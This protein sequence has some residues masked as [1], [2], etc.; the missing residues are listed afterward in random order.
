MTSKFY[1]MALPIVS[2]GPVFWHVIEGTADPVHDV[3]HS[4]FID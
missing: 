1:V 3:R 4:C 2:Q